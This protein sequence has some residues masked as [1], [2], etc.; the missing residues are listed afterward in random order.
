MALKVIPRSS[1]DM[2]VCADC[3]QINRRIWGSI[4]E[5]EQTQA[6]YYVHWTH[7]QLST[8]GARFELVIGEWG[9]GTSPDD[10]YAVMLEYRRTDDG[11]GFRVIDAGERLHHLAHTAC[12]REDII[13]K[14][15]TQFAFKLVD[16]ILAQDV[17]MK[18]FQ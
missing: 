8:H 5:D 17:R 18:D 1:H 4:A 7:R 11:P 13:D 14:P 10:R 3:G 6:V 15:I 9:E 16:A 12:L 2:G